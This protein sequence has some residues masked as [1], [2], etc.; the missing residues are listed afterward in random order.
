[1][2]ATN[3]RSRD[4]VPD[5]LPATR[6]D[7]AQDGLDGAP[8]VKPCWSDRAVDTERRFGPCLSGWSETPADAS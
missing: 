8:T 7:P 3:T 2:K 6:V 1:M 5:L 4:Q